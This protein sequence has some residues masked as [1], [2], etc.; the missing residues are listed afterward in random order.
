MAETRLTWL[1]VKFGFLSSC[2]TSR[3]VRRVS[4][5]TNYVMLIPSTGRRFSSQSGSQA[6]IARASTSSL[7]HAPLE[8]KPKPVGLGRRSPARSSSPQPVT[9]A[10]L[11]VPGGQSCGASS[12]W[13]PIRLHAD[14]V[15]QAGRLW[16]EAAGKPNADLSLE[17]RPR[18]RLRHPAGSHPVWLPRQHPHPRQHP[19]RPKQHPGPHSAAAGPQPP[20]VPPP[21]HRLRSAREIY[22][23][24]PSGDSFSVLQI[25]GACR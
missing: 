20:K 8:A 11:Q 25:C 2:L 7:R 22:G 17:D 19:S 3:P 9:G 16:K 21:G 12:A 10:V 14:R 23:K 6:K 15:L 1:N 18:S 13:R 5:I 24:V 4:T